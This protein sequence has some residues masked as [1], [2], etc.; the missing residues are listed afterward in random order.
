MAADVDRMSGGRLI[1]GLGV[2][3]DEHEFTQLGLSMPTVKQRLAALEET[4][5]LVRELWQHALR[6]APVQVPRIPILIGGGG[7][8]STL[9]QVA[10]YA[11]AASLVPAGR[12]EGLDALS[13]TDVQRK[14]AALE[15]YC[16]ETRRPYSSVLLTKSAIPVVISETRGGAQKKLEMV[17]ERL[18]THFATLTVAGTP[19]DAVH[20]FQPFVESGI[21]YFT[22]FV[23]GND[24]ETLRL[25]SEDVRPA[26][27][28]L[29]TQAA[30]A[31][32]RWTGVG[33][34]V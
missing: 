20:A 3:I 22:P 5:R 27:T 16:A 18:R 15:R 28:V 2:G 21:R 7:E 32:R 25:L 13:V 26:L 12:G 33:A 6:P 24:L 23:I 1:L 14:A 4:V 34:V 29:A 19:E 10:M 30:P 31:L 11:D 17:P 9:R 8:K